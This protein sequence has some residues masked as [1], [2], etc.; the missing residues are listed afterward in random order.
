MTEQG[1]SGPT[2]FVVLGGYLGAGKTRLATTLARYLKETHG[3]SVAIITNDQGNVLVDTEYVRNAGFDVRE[4]LGGCFCSNLPE[5]VKNARSLVQMG[6]PDVIIAEPIGTSTNIL[7]SVLVPL[8]TMH[9]GEF[10]VAPLMVVVDGTSAKKLLDKSLAVGPS[11]KLIPVQQAHD[12]E[13]ILVSKADLMAHSGVEEVICVINNEVPSAEIIPYSSVTMENIDKI[14]TAV[15]SSRS[16]TKVPMAVDNRF[17]AMEKASM[18]WF[19]ASAGIATAGKLD[20][21]AYITEILRGV[22]VRFGTGAV[23]HVK[24][25]VES[26][27]VAVKMSLVQDSLQTDGIKGGRFLEGEG[28]IVMNARISATPEEL[29]RSLLE[30]LQRSS[31]S[32][33]VRL[34]DLKHASLRPRGETPSFL[35]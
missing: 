34:V 31:S 8:R 15:L 5:F 23:A 32:V 28:R 22:A 13:M 33:G 7:A 1:R 9:P 11:R 2:R 21:Y 4:I 30:E 25:M 10:D 35:K 24:V 12:A 3:K 14:A 16:S 27:K 18:G 6:R 17:F 19:N 29:E 20:L 26:E